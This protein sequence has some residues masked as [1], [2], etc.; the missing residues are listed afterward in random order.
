[1][2]FL[3]MLIGAALAAFVGAGM[4]EENTGW[5]AAILGA[6]IGLLLNQLRRVRARLT[7]IEQALARAV[8]APV[9]ATRVEPLTAAAPAAEAAPV[10][11]PTAAAPPSEDAIAAPVDAALARSA[12]AAP[13]S[14]A[15]ESAAAPPDLPPARPA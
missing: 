4:F 6:M 3:F 13:A 1:M 10:P 14:D 5:T 12:V 8:A 15:I 11:A 9:A 7:N 2:S